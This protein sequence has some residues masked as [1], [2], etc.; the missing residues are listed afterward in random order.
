[1][2]L[3]I[4]WGDVHELCVCTCDLFVRVLYGSTVCKC[5]GVYVLNVRTNMYI[6]FLTGVDTT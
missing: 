6:C 1:M 4:V 2:H 3:N 5:V